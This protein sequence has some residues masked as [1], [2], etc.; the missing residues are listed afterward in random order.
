MGLQN[1]RNIGIVAH[2]DAGKTT[3]TERVL[4][5]TGMKRTLGEVHEGTATMDF[6]KQEQERGITI[7]SAAIS[8]KWND[9]SI[10]IIDTPGHVDFTIEVERSM[11]V[12]D[13]ITSVFCG[14]GGVEPQSETVWGQAD[15][16]RVPRIAFVNKLDR[17]G[18]DYFDVI[19]QLND[20]LDANAIAFQVPIGKEDG[21]IGLIDL[22]EMKAITFPE[23]QRVIGDIPDEYKGEVETHRQALLEKL[24][25]FND[26]IAELYLDEKP[27]P[28]DLIKRVTRH[29]VQRLLLTPVFAGAAYKNV[30][31]QLLLDAIVDYLP[32]P[33]D[34]GAITGYDIDDHEKTHM[35]HPTE[36]D[37][38]SALA[39][40]I[41][42]DPYVGQQTFVRTY[43]GVLKAGQQVYNATNG[44]KE[45]VGRILRIRAK[46]REEVEQVGPGDIVALIGMKDTHTGHTLCDPGTPILLES[47]TVPETVI[48]VKVSTETQKDLDKLHQSLRKMALEDPSFQVRVVERTA[49]TVIA[50]M[51]ELHLEIIVDRLKTDFG[52]EANVGAPSVEYRETVTAES[53]HAYKHVKQSGGKGQFAHTVMRVEPNPGGG[54]EFVDHITGGSIPQEFIPAVRHGIADTIKAGI[55]AD[56]PVVDVRVVLIDGSFHA[57]DSSE[58]AFRTCASICFKE[59]FRRANPKLMEPVMALEIATP[60]EHIGDIVGDLNR[61]RGRVLNMRRYRAGSQK[62]SAEAPLMELFGYATTLRSLSSGR[63]NYA[64]EVAR[65][66]AMPAKLQETVLE[67]ARKRIAAAHGQ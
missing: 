62:L 63:A 2:I 20:R 53:Q 36:N 18:A 1:V 57:V 27:V 4:F 49:E 14:V 39:F 61:R 8:C 44:K 55:L 47:L 16:Y 25:E 3:V 35:R 17:P 66:D 34:A 59:A 33:L 67:E 22:V 12:L 65:Y 23:K 50:G 58:M 32:S 41:I 21:F 51:G 5:F 24:S 56:Y 52:V 19:A 43:S 6:M 7:A 15:R 40:K 26:E 38:F 46:E 30:G 29:C 42:H 11:R 28:T 10:N 54:F 9:A 48:S 37:P 45:R 13:G 64:M 60:D 31:V